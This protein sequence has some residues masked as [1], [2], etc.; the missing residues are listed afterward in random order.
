MGERSQAKA[1][2]ERERRKFR[3]DCDA[4]AAELFSLLDR[5]DRQVKARIN[6]DSRT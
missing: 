2:T 3:D 5:I 6:R 4:N 1:D